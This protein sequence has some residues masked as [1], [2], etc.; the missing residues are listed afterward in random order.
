MSDGL[1]TQSVPVQDA[2]ASDQAKKG[3]FATQSG[4]IV[5]IVIGLGVLGIVAGIAIAIVLFVL[6]GDTGADDGVQVQ[7]QQPAASETGG[8]NTPALALAQ[9]SA[10]VPNSEVFTFRNIFTPLLKEVES[11]TDTSTTDDADDDDVTP[12]T[13]G[14]LYLND[15][16]TEDGELKAVL[17]LDDE[18][19]TLGVGEAIPNSPWEVLRITST[20]VTMLYGEEVQ[21]SL[22][23]GQGITK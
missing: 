3:F 12:T 13:A 20:T 5:G 15:I 16:I 10:E 7:P 11:S 9:A 19:Y 22:A 1:E 4:R 6:G 23:I 8:E 18:T 21:V 17:E 14:T 2:P